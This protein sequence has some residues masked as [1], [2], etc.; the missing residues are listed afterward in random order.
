[1]LSIRCRHPHHLAYFHEAAGGPAGGWRHLIDSNYDWGQDLFH[2]KGWLDDHPEARLLRLACMSAVDP[3]VLG[4]DY[5]L[6][7]QE[8]GSPAPGW[9]AV[10]ANFV[11]GLPY[12]APDGTGGY[13]YIPAGAYRYFQRFQPVARAGR[14][15]FIYH[16]TRDET[17]PRG[18]AL[19]GPP[20]EADP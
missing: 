2:L 19:G 11:C 12:L 5:E 9:F 7:P 10:S 8:S 18:A 1:L 14:T 6:P 4:I 3:A 13:R 17:A 16:L 20:T 15:I